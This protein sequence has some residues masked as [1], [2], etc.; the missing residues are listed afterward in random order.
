MTPNAQYPSGRTSLCGSTLPHQPRTKHLRTQ[1]GGNRRQPGPQSQRPRPPQHRAD[2]AEDPRRVA[3]QAG[4]RGWSKTPPA[5]PREPFPVPPGSCPAARDGA[6]RDRRRT[7]FPPGRG[8]AL[9]PRW[10]WP[11]P[12]ASLPVTGAGR[13]HVPLP[14]EVGARFQFRVSRCRELLSAAAAR[15][16]V[17]PV[18]AP[19][20]PPPCRSPAPS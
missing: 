8:S 14:P 1:K 12:P 15:T 6:V 9:R 5:A 2:A 17:R 16:P 7:A 20:P 3:S 13:R 10:K 19:A 4:D 18:P 11:A